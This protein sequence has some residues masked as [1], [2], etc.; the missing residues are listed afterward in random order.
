M[1]IQRRKQG[2]SAIP[3]SPPRTVRNYNPD[4]VQWSS[5]LRFCSGQFLLVL[6]PLSLLRRS[7]VLCR[8]RG[9]S[10][11]PSLDSKVGPVETLRR[12]YNTT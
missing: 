4:R 5:Q 2:G 8:E 1:Y 12:G 9:Q 10:T 7:R 3:R 11:L 6:V